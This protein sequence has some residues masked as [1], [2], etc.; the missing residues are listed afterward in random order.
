M[1][2]LVF[3]SNL[4]L[5]M[6]LGIHTYAGVSLMYPLSSVPIIDACSSETI[7]YDLKSLLNVSIQ[8]PSELF[9]C[10]LRFLK[11][12]QVKKKKL[13]YSSLVMQIIELSDIEI[14]VHTFPFLL[15]WT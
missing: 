9:F 11:Q 15:D 4:H 5:E 1:E 12:E 3:N 10:P 7:S 2:N 8:I 14:I 6:F 13:I